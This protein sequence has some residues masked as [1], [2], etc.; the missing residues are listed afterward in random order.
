MTDSTRR[1]AELDAQAVQSVMQPSLPCHETIIFVRQHGRMETGTNPRMSQALP[2]P[3]LRPAIPD[4][5]DLAQYGLF[6]HLGS[7]T[8]P[9]RLELAVQALGKTLRCWQGNVRLLVATSGTQP[10]RTLLPP[11][12]EF[13]APGAL[14]RRLRSNDAEVLGPAFS[15]PQ[16]DITLHAIAS[17]VPLGALNL[18]PMPDEATAGLQLEG[19]VFL[20]VARSAERSH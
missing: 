16:G 17:G 14:R 18:A 11:H 12:C 9:G 6:I 19:H 3:A 15:D 8:G 7:A 10:Q 5:A 4:T 2:L 20:A 1:R 13:L